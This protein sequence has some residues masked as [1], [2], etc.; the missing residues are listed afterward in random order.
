[1][2]HISQ[3]ELDQFERSLK[4]Y[5]RGEL[6]FEEF[7]KVRVWQGVYTL[8]AGAEAKLYM[9]RVKIPQGRL[10]PAQMEKVAGL[11]EK[12]S[13]DQWVHITTRQGME[14]FGIEQKHLIEV[15]RSLAEVDLTTRETGGN[16][17]RNVTACPFSGVAQD[18]LFDVTP[19]GQA[20]TR[21]F[22]RHPLAQDLPRKVKVGFEGCR[23]G[24]HIRAM[25]QDIGIFA[26]VQ[27]GQRGFQVYVGG[28]L[29]GA[30]RQA[31]LLEVFTPADQILA[32]GEAILTVFDQHGSRK[33]R[34]RARLKYLIQD[35]GIKKFHVEVAAARNHI[36]KEGRKWPAL[37]GLEELPPT[38]S[39]PPS[40]KTKKIDGSGWLRW[41]AYNIAAQ[42]QAKYYAVF[43]RCPLG[44]ITA[45]QLRVAARAAQ[46]YCGGRVRTTITQ[47][48]LLRWVHQKDLVD[49]YRE[50]DTVGL[51]R[52]CAEH[53]MDI[54]RCAGSSTCLS[55][56]TNS[57]GMAL[58][59]G[60]LFSNGLSQDPEIFN[61]VVKVSGCPHA[62]GQHH[63][64]DL[65]LHGAIK[66]ASGRAVPHYQILLG[67]GT[68]RGKARF[69]KPVLPVPAKKIPEAVSHL[70]KFYQSR[71]EVGESLKNF[72]DRTGVER[73]R[74]ELTGF[75]PIPPYEQDPEIYKDWGSDRDF[76][77]QAKKGECSA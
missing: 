77:L 32:T 18:E 14:L 12:Y 59:L 76:Q 64:A 5:D 2:S 53:V 67:G 37:E 68:E 1:M 26:A 3:P 39:D 69:A 8:R 50:L 71:R 33:S 21:Y 52:C 58:E 16:G 75:T 47:N 73:V 28:G 20:F 40:E 54:T 15:L 46:N 22:L 4:Q 38:L 44:D 61:L 23:S 19:Y 24:D 62:C 25:V 34:D 31:E 13:R 51:T 17:V 70:L 55:A 42:K 60:K 27:G 41:L 66:T 57:R 9:V 7:R 35:W 10:N 30:P 6:D 29:G 36:I 74:E 49:L 11:A 56:M 43:I 63:I 72:V 65:G 45:E 48:L